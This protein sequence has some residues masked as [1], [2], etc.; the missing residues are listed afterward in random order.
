M[1]L[2]MAL[3]GITS[4]LHLKE[5]TITC[6]RMQ[7]SLSIGRFLSAMAESWK[8]LKTLNVFCCCLLCDRI[9]IDQLQC[10]NC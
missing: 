2:F 1:T 9:E 7:H 4:F 8:K 3:D 10:M 5:V 6:K